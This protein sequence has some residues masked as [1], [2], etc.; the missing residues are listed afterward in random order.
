MAVA[1]T[2]ALPSCAESAVVLDGCGNNIAWHRSDVRAYDLRNGQLVWTTKVPHDIGYLV[3]VDSD[4]VR[5]PTRSATSDAI[6]RIA[7]GQLVGDQRHEAPPP[8]RADNGSIV[9]STTP[10]PPPAWDVVTGDVRVT[11]DP[12][13]S[14]ASGMALTATRLSTGETLWS[15]QVLSPDDVKRGRTRSR[16]VFVDGIAVIAIGDPMPTCV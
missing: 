12:I 9:G 6:L 1:V 4:H 14:G 10:Q 16:P 11:V 8:T 2:A 13:I 15:T 5:V 3:I 7:D